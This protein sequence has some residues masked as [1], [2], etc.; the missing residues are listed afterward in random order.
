MAFII[1]CDD[2]R[3][4]G[5]VMALMDRSNPVAIHKHSGWWTV[6]PKYVRVYYKKQTAEEVVGRLKHNNPRIVGHAE[7]IKALQDQN[8]E[9]DLS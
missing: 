3:T 4:S 7:G 6:N 9:T 2:R 8:N 5:R 1:I